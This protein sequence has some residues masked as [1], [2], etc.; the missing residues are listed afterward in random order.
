MHVDTLYCDDNSTFVQIIFSDRQAIE[1]QGFTKT[2]ITQTH[3][4]RT[5][6]E[7]GVRSPVSLTTFKVEGMSPTSC[8]H[9]GLHCGLRILCVGSLLIF[10]FISARQIPPHTEELFSQLVSQNKTTTDTQES[11]NQN[12]S[13]FVKPNRCS[14]TF[15]KVDLEHAEQLN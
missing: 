12:R 3:T 10:A 7:L 14:A 13:P 9:A 15:G 4:V 1:F 2:F 6:P 8:S 5:F 11:T